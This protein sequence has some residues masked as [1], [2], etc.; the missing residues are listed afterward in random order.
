[1]RS[2]NENFDVFNSRDD[3]YLVFTKKV[4][5]LFILYFKE[6]LQFTYQLSFKPNHNSVKEDKGVFVTE[7]LDQSI[8]TRTYKY[9]EIYPAS[10]CEISHVIIC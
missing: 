7:Y 9:K 4:N 1:M 3:I 8:V 6:D 5:F 10:N 2:T